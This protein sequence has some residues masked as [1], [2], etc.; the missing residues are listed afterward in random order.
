MF[1]ILT[2]PWSAFCFPKVLLRWFTACQA[3]HTHTHTNSKREGEEEKERGKFWFRFLWISMCCT[4]LQPSHTRFAIA[5]RMHE[6]IAYFFN[7]NAKIRFYDLIAHFVRYYIFVF[8]WTF[9]PWLPSFL[10]VFRLRWMSAKSTSH[11]HSHTQV[12]ARSHM[13]T[14]AHAHTN[15][16][17]Q[18]KMTIIELYTRTYFYC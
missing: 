6:L 2:I 16:R 11:T 3:A 4:W 5:G 13:Q 7:D 10:V 9:G 14:Q 8:W 18:V 17:L 15:T 12:Y 1:K